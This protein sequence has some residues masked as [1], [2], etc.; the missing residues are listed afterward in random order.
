MAAPAVDQAGT[1]APNNKARLVLTTPAVQPFAPA[2][3]RASEPETRRV[4]WPSTNRRRRWQGA[5][6]V[7]GLAAVG[8]PGEHRTARDNEQHAEHN[9]AIGVFLEDH[10]GQQGR[11]DRFQIEHEG[12][13]VRIGMGEAKHQQSRAQMWTSVMP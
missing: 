3:N 10:P 1:D 13:G 7:R 4:R 12:G 5:D 11:D 6:P 8:G 9:T 2:M